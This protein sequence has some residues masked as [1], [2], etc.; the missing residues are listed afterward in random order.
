MVFE[1]VGCGKNQTTGLVGISTACLLCLFIC[2]ASSTKPRQWNASGT[3]SPGSP[4]TSVGDVEPVHLTPHWRSYW[5]T[6]PFKPKSITLFTACLVFRFPASL[7]S[8]MLN[9]SGMLPFVECRYHVPGGIHFVVLK[10][11]QLWGY[12]ESLVKGL[13]RVS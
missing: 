6:L 12:R 8:I 3:F 5:L 4:T 10:G 11:P 9:I 2:G 7:R 1:N 13:L